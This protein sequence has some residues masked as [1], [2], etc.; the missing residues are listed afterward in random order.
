MTS[1]IDPAYTCMA[2]SRHFSTTGNVKRHLESNKVCKDW[3]DL[4]TSKQSY[5]MLYDVIQNNEVTYEDVAATVVPQ[6]SD[7]TCKYCGKQFMSTSALAKHM[8][9]SKACE[10]WRINEL[11]MNSQRLISEKHFSHSERKSSNAGGDVKKKA[12]ACGQTQNFGLQGWSWTTSTEAR[13]SFAG[14]EAPKYS[15]CHIIWN[16]FL[17]DKEFAQKDDIETICQ[18]N[19]VTYMIAIMPDIAAFNAAT[20]HLSLKT[21]VMLYDGHDTRLDTQRFDEECARIDAIRAKRDYVMVCCNKGFQRSVPFLCYYLCKFHPDEVPNVERAIDI[22]LPQVDKARYAEERDKYI[23]IVEQ[24]FCKNGC[25][26]F[27]RTPWS[28][29]IE[30]R[31]SCQAEPS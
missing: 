15:L 26:A 10:K 8:R 20:S 6:F 30:E 14:F 28:I 12:D 13:E 5:T 2:C 7:N 23:D 31:R 18:E 1:E 17:I 19:K 25:S 16:L 24:L 9:S 4:P 11:V 21:S 22:I 27:T 29:C 3:L